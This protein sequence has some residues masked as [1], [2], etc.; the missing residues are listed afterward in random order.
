[1][2][3]YA[4]AVALFVAASLSLAALPE[5]PLPEI[6]DPGAAAI[7]Q[8]Q[9]PPDPPIQFHRVTGYCSCPLCCGQWSDGYTASGHRA[10]PG[11]T[12]AADT[13]IWNMGTCLELPGIG[14]RVVEDT[15]ASI[16]GDRLDVY[17]ESHDEA[18]RFGIRFLPVWSC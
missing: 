9:A 18:L 13:S 12:V 8:P 4:L 14:R 1:M 3:S 7:F 6:T 10:V 11:R 17:F 5:V 15:G 16:L 2:R